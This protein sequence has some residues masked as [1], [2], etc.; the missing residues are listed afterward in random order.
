MITA[1]LPRFLQL[2]AEKKMQLK[3]RSHPRCV[4]SWARCW[5]GGFRGHGTG[6]VSP[7]I[8]PP[9]D[10]RE[11]KPHWWSSTQK[12]GAA[13]SGKGEGADP[14]RAPGTVLPAGPN[15]LSRSA[16]Q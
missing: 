11:K 13:Q 16:A 2:S 5:G 10:E 15:V 14:W 12:R 4:P 8:H 7:C 9:M 1:E 3:G 6:A